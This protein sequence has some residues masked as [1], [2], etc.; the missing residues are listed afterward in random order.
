M[1]SCGATSKRSRGKLWEDALLRESQVQRIINLRPWQPVRAGEPD[2]NPF[3]CQFLHGCVEEYINLAFGDSIVHPAKKSFLDGAMKNGDA[4]VS[5][6]EL[7]SGD[8]LVH[9]EH[10]VTLDNDFHRFIPPQRVY[11]HRDRRPELPLVPGVVPEASL[12]ST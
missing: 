2:V 10:A 9:A 6:A 3:V 8:F 4:N 12:V 1:I 5:A 7:L 11:Y